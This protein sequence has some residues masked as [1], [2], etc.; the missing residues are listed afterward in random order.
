[1]AISKLAFFGQPGTYEATLF[2]EGFES[3][4]GS[5]TAVNDSN[6]EWIASTT[7]NSLITGSTSNNSA[8]ISDDSGTSWDYTSTSEV[9][10]IYADITFPT[11]GEDF[12]L[13]FKWAGEGED[14]SGAS[15]WD[16]MRVSLAPTSETPAAGTE[17]TST[18]R[19][20]YGS[21]AQNYGKYNEGHPDY[22]DPP[23]SDSPKTY[24]QETVPLTEF[25]EG[26]ALAG[27]TKRLIFTWKNDGSIS[28]ATPISIDDIQITYTA[29]NGTSSE[30]SLGTLQQRLPS[31]NLILL[32]DPS[33][34]T[35]TDNGTTPVSSNG[36]LVYRIDDLSP[37]GE[38][39]L[40]AS[41]TNRP[42]WY[43][44]GQGQRPYV[45]FDGVDN[46]LEIADNA[47]HSTDDMSI[48]FV[49]RN[50]DITPSIYDTYFMKSD[51]I[52]WNDGYG[53]WMNSSNDLGTF[54]NNYS[55]NN[56][57]NSEHDTNPSDP[58][59]LCYR[60]KTSAATYE[61]NNLLNDGTEQTGTTASSLTTS[62][63][64]L[65]IGKGAGGS[66]YGTFK[67]YT[68]VMYDTYHDD[69]TR[70]TVMSAL[71]TYFGGIY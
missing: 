19:L 70:A 71:N 38:N 54:V 6:N 18:Y 32:L 16:Y 44:S 69:A 41:S 63:S 62:T 43:E 21:S 34:E 9:S 30:P 47:A 27:Q 12:T 11:T 56:V 3:G 28:G 36:D 67:M 14:G 1:M 39:A 31:D 60:F 33:F 17:I 29:A 55:S 26:T 52:S 23:D 46:F 5:F 57:T 64:P 25:S 49:F 42:S 40:Q 35:Y 48:Y 2:E 8:F 37:T 20:D 7:A 50:D 13:K 65:V 10:H 45:E 4:L 68:M 24:F 58:K 66:Y 53:A 15:S 61:N 22:P 51:S 59:I